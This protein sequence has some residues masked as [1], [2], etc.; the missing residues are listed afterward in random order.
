MEEMVEMIDAS[1][2]SFRL[3]GVGASGYFASSYA[4][5]APN[6]IK[7]A[8]YYTYTPC[9]RLGGNAAI[10]MDELT[11]VGSAIGMVAAGHCADLWGRK[12]L[13]GWELLTLIVAILGVTSASEGFRSQLPDG[14]YNY[15]TDIYAW[16]AWWRFVLGLAIGAEHPL[17][18]IITAE[19]AATQS[20]GRMLALVFAMLPLARLLA[21][22]IGLAALRISSAQN[23]LSPDLRL[24]DDAAFVSKHVADQVWRWDMGVAIIPAALAVFFRFTIPEPPRFYAHIRKNLAEALRVVRENGAIKE[25]KNAAPESA[26]P[27]DRRSEATVSPQYDASS[28][29]DSIADKGAGRFKR[30][31]GWLAGAKLYLRM[32]DARKRLRVITLLC[33]ISE[34]GW[35]C[36]SK[37]SHTSM[38]TFWHDSSTSTTAKRSYFDDTKCPE[39]NLW[40]S[41]PTDD[42][43][44]LYHELEGNSYRFMYVSS[45]GS[46]AGSIVLAI[47]INRFH[48]K[49]MMMVSFLALALL[50]AVSGA[51]LTGT[52]DPN[53]DDVHPS[54]NVLFALMH[55]FYAFGP[56]T[57]IYIL[58]VEMFPT[59]YRGTF[60]GLTA[61]A[62]KV[63][64]VAIRPVIGFTSKFPRSLGIRLMC[65]APL[66]LVAAW[67]CRD[68]PL[69]Q[70][71]V[72]GE[73]DS[74][75]VGRRQRHER[76]FLKTVQ[77][78]MERLET[79]RLEDIS[80]KPE[81]LTRAGEGSGA[82]LTTPV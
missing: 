3:F 16:L 29:N 45:A 8:L 33:L 9:G 51:I 79:M 23:G 63:A 39:Y 40:K 48:R 75:D 30:W 53:D 12:K 34:T 54:A 80:T 68:L 65:V 11:L 26:A 44:T 21:Y 13:Y 76:S 78:G 7:T 71:P 36:L 58:A 49:T 20:R 74:A 62:G 66:L 19:W 27:R 31:I 24:E 14:T 10:V 1:G 81:E 4:L 17:V 72:G 28:D 77:Q 2:F 55:F 60:Y 22:G 56:R 69:V 61:A 35:Y 70:V 73:P 25:R 57:L 37:D 46:I 38:S 6:V 67:L 5:F 42:A 18:S 43:A 50:F 15:S 64:A 47:V 82:Q 41:D 52:Y 59:E 32:T